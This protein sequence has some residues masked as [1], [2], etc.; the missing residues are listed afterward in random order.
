VP[1]IDLERVW[2]LA[3]SKVALLEALK[4]VEPV[5]LEFDN[6]EF[7]LEWVACFIPIA[8][9]WPLRDMLWRFRDGMLKRD[10]YNHHGWYRVLGVEGALYAL[11]EGEEQEDKLDD[12]EYLLE[13]ALANASH[14][15]SGLRSHASNVLAL[16]GP[17][18]GFT[19]YRFQRPMSENI[20]HGHA[21]DEIAALVAVSKGSA[22]EKR[23]VLK[24]WWAEAGEPLK[25]PLA[26]LASGE[27]IANP[28]YAKLSG[29]NRNALVELACSAPVG[30]AVSSEPGALGSLLKDEHV[31]ALLPRSAAFL[32]DRALTVHPLLQPEVH[33]VDNPSGPKSEH[34][35]RTGT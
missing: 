28:F 35:D 7:F 10:D 12:P 26:R 3:V 18:L 24:A 9:D 6:A 13:N 5:P 2:R 21:L 25:S 1:S 8:I 33:V 19:R 16:I 23:E 22:L 27:A 34:Q 32:L 4:D 31:A 14:R 15:S 17:R 29:V 11:Q 20:E 30:P